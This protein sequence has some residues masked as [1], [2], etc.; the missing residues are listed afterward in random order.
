MFQVTVLFLLTLT[1]SPAQETR[2][3]KVEFDEASMEDLVG[4]LREGA[5]GKARNVLVDP[6]VNREIRVTLTLHDVTKSVAFAYAAELGG[7]RRD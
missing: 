3:P 2:I 5:T 1:E 6:R 4:F 7:F